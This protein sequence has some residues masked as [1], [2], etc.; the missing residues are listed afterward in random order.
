MEDHSCN[1]G[2]GAVWDLHL[3]RNLFDQEIDDLALLP[4]VIEKASMPTE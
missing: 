1:N 2:S 4:Q 3:W